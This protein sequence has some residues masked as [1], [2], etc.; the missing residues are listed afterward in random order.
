LSRRRPIGAEPRNGGV[1]L[2]VWAPSARR[3]RVVFEDGLP[4]VE[5]DAEAHGY[6]AGFAPSAGVGARYRFRLDDR[7]LLV[8]DPASRWQPDG[9]HG[10][11]QVIDPDAFSWTDRGWRGIEIH[12]QILY[13]LHFGTFTPQGTFA[14]AMAE[15]PKLVELGVT[16][17]ELMPVAEFAGS[18]GW[19]YDGVDLW[20]P[21]RNYGTPDDL[22]RFVDRAHALGLGVMLDVVYNHLGP[23]GNY[24]RE[25]SP[26]YFTDRHANEWGESLDFDGPDSGPVRE[27]FVEN[28]CYWIDEFHVDGLRLDATHAIHDASEIHVVRE[29]GNRAR[30][31]AGRRSVVI[32]AE[33]DLQLGEIP[34]STAAGGWGLDGVWND[35]FHHTALVAATGRREFYYRDFLGGPQELIS[36]TKWGYLFQGQ[37]YGRDHRPRGTP[38][39]DL[40]AHSYVSYI[41]NHD[42]VAHS[43]RGLRL[44]QL[45]S[46]GR[47]RALTALLLLG[48]GTPMLFQGQEFASPRPFLFFADHVPE[49]A[50]L[51][52]KGRREFL[53]QFP[54]LAG[55]EVEDIIAVPDDPRTF[56]RCKLDP[57]EREQ[58]AGVVAMHRELIALR[59]GERAFVEQRS[60]ILHGAVLGTDAFVLRWV[61]GGDDDR[62]LLV[63]LGRDLALDPAPEPLLAPPAGRRWSVQWSS[64]DPRWGGAGTPPPDTDEGWRL[65]GHAAL[66]LRPTPV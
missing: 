56:A 8:P 47:W 33:N 46:P 7:E 9:V 50:E 64:E 1:D 35:D 6:F 37:R 5:L 20:A 53:A 30:A 48:P 63:N 10:A 66:L 16:T 29:L 31:A 59:K 14:A 57:A 13:E 27:F 19:G 40:P 11:S 58:N 26:H 43:G 65:L 39:F 52:R 24:L 36:A 22:R 44:R 55:P 34:R 17:V 54:S 41:E 60:D 23:D 18:F 62:L 3:V 2:R 42:Q 45:T 12:G 49:L 4:T 38:A 61:T 15:L 25:F 32:V 28:A 21:T 51:V